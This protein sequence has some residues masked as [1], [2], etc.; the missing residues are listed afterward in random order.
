MRLGLA[1]GISWRLA[2]TRTPILSWGSRHGTV[3]RR[4][5]RA[6]VVFVSLVVVLFQKQSVMNIWIR[7]CDS[8]FAKTVAS[9]T[10]VDIDEDHGA[11]MV[12][13]VGSADSFLD[14][15]V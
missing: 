11:S 13:D 8:P 9:E 10:V 2:L 4:G 14:A 3:G 1:L 6:I 7:F 5:L 12:D 15:I